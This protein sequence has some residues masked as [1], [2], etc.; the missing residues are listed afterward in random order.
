MRLWRCLSRVLLTLPPPVCVGNF[1]NHKGPFTHLKIEHAAFN[2][3]IHI[4]HVD[5]RRRSA[6]E[7]EIEQVCAW[8][9]R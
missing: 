5:V 4:P 3:T 1:V 9:L 6:T 8:A 7:A 2:G